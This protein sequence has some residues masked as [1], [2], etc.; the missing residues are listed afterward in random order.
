M[1]GPMRRQC[2]WENS[3]G[4]PKL[5]RQ[6]NRENLSVV[7]LDTDHLSVLEWETDAPPSS[8]S[9]TPSSCL[10]ISLVLPG[11][12]DS[13][14]KTGHIDTLLFQNRR[15]AGAEEDTEGLQQVELFEHGGDF[16]IALT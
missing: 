15:R 9:T 13:R 16:G 3:T 6:S 4:I 5:L 11:C 8:S 10:G 2:G 12:L 14:S 1:I 7:V